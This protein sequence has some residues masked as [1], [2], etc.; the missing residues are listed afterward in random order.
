MV[1][2][3]IAMLVIAM[4][5]QQIA[6]LVTGIVVQIVMHQV[7]LLGKG[8]TKEMEDGP[9]EVT[10]VM[11]LGVLVDMAEVVHVLGVVLVGLLALVGVTVIDPHPM[12]VLAGVLE[13]VLMMIATEE[14]Y[15]AAEQRHLVCFCYESVFIFRYIDASTLCYSAVQFVLLV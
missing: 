12:T 11:N 14:G 3:A 8:A 1:L 4:H 6:I 9:A 13:L 5:Q 15:L 2:G 7:A 10:T